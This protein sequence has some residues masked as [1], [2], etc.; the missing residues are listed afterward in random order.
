MV[1]EYYTPTIEEFVQGFQFQQL[2]R[3][4]GDKIGGVCYLTKGGS[5]KTEWYYA[6]ED[7][8][9]DVVV[10]WDREPEIVT[11]EG[12]GMTCTY[13]ELPMWDWA[14]WVNPGYITNLIKDGK[15]RARV[16]NISKQL[17]IS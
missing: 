17:Q 16:N 11:T 15:V 10:Y 2:I 6:D 13:K 3:Q 4:K 12:Y 7:Q 14:P 9:V 8:W 5:S 1:N